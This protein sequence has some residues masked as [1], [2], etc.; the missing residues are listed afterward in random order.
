MPY[1]SQFERQAIEKGKLEGRAEGRT[2]GRAEGRAEGKL[3]GKVE[4]LTQLLQRRLG[5]IPSSLLLQIASLPSNK[6]ETLG[7]A[8][9]DFQQP[10]DLAAWLT[11]NHC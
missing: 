11:Q 7:D 9:F 8:I 10:S 3:E 2:E 6:L 1:I 5:I 4:L